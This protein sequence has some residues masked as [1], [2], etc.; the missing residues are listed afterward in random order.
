MIA[1][2]RGQHALNL[3]TIQTGHRNIQYGAAGNRHVMLI[4]E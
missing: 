4:E 3:Q 2:G 1:A